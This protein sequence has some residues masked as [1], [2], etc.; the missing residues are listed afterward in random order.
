M[1]KTNE[2]Y[3]AQQ[4]NLYWE[5]R[6]GPYCLPHDGGNTVAFL[7]LQNLTTRYQSIIDRAS[8]RT[9]V[10][11]DERFDSVTLGYLAQREISLRLFSS[12]K[13]SVSEFAWNG[14]PVLPI[15]LLK[16]LSR[17][18]ILIN[19]TDQFAQP[20]V[21]FRALTDHT[22][23]EIM[24]ETIRKT[25]EL[26]AAP[27]M[28][29]LTPVETGPGANLT[30]D[31]QLEAVLRAQ[32]QP[33]YSHPCCT[34]SMMRREIGGVVGPDMKVHGVNG[35]SVVDASIIPLI[36]ATHPSSTVYAVAE[37]VA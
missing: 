3:A 9:L 35:L 30:T 23:V 15:T 8:S 11:E 34:C 27:A 4:L 26:M 33:T 18:S 19:S 13:A 10:A 14:S 1:L 31:A 12:T 6:E 21:D 24:I 5:S 37:K 7:P 36:P 20:E 17:G 28:Q 22:D 29:E 25:R 32:A 16:P 2:T